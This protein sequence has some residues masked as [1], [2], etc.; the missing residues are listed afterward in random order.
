MSIIE[1]LLFSSTAATFISMLTLVATGEVISPAT[2]FMVLAFMNILRIAVSIRLGN[3]VP[4]AFELFVSFQRIE[5][6][7]LL[8]NMPLDPLEYEQ[9]SFGRGHI[10][11]NVNTYAQLLTRNPSPKNR[12]TIQGNIPGNQDVSVNENVQQ[13]KPRNIN[14]SVS[15]LTWKFNELSGE[16][17][18]LQ[19]VSFE[20]SKKSLTVITGQ[21]GS[22]KSTLLASIAGE[23]TKTRGSVVY[24]GTIA[25]VPQTAW[26]FSGTLRENVL[27]GESY[28]E[29][30]YAEVIEIC[31]LVED[32]NR[33][34]NGDSTFVGE[35]GVILSGGQRARVNLARAMY[36][37]A[38]IYLLDDPLS[39][40]DAKVGEHIFNQC[41]CNF[42]A[43]KI[44][45]LVT[46]TKKH[47]MAADQVVVLHKGCVLGKGSLYDLQGSEEI[48]AIIDASASTK[49]QKRTPTTRQEDDPRHSSSDPTIGSLDEHLEISEE[50]KATGKI[51]SALYWDYFR[52]GMHPAVVIAVV[53]LFLATQG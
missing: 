29:R 53:G 44:T 40:V 28:D 51:S 20:A 26:L 43:E 21:V 8:D 12:R 24:S 1:S 16:R 3:G 11:E 10:K 49:D 46:Y 50:E 34:P 4:L 6:F 18:I 52:A 23:A 14:L 22:G 30:K 48:D 25:Y 42:L 15:N 31:S 41:I 47:M 2:A 33:F 45:I 17:Y 27:F 38:D 35:H 9:T 39:A 37:D 5:R 36:A 13:S 19:D 7:L 32:I